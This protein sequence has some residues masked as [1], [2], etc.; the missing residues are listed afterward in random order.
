MKF[1]G[2][3][4]VVNYEADNAEKYKTEGL[5]SKISG[6]LAYDAKLTLS[7]RNE[8][9]NKINFLTPQ[10][11]IRHAPGHMRNI[12]NDD[13]KLSYSN[14]F[15]INKNTQVDVVERGTSATLGVEISNNNL[16]KAI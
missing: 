12:Q 6:V 15:S 10:F 7:K 1:K 13:L 9:K 3:F 5:N 4:K 11:S 14:L 2:L 16:I 8:I